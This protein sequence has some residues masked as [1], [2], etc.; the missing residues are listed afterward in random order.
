MNSPRGEGGGDATLV[1]IG[2]AAHS[3]RRRPGNHRTSCTHC[4][5]P[6]QAQIDAMYAKLDADEAAASLARHRAAKAAAA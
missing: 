2:A 6:P 3:V 4:V 1:A 5:P